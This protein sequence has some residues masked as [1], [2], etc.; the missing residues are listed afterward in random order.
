MLTSLP[1]NTLSISGASALA[2]YSVGITKRAEF[3][4]ICLRYFKHLSRTT[5]LE[6]NRAEWV[7]L[8]EVHFSIT[9][10]IGASRI[11]EQTSEKR[12]KISLPKASG[13]RLVFD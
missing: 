7:V 4:I 1:A 5:F 9:R 3:Q 12:G 8:T 10:I 2:P 6:I 11:A 13:F